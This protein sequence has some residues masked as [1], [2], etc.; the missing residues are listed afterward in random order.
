MK[1][2]L[3]PFKPVLARTSENAK[4]FATFYGGCTVINNNKIYYVC[5]E[6]G[7]FQ[8]CIPYNENTAH[9]LD[10]NEPYEE[11]EPKVWHVV[12]INNRGESWDFTDDELDRFIKTAV[13][14][15]KDITKFYVNRISSIR[16]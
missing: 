2:K 8:Y 14:N 16:K 3:E 13:I 11:P 6:G 9:L 7:H 10:T 5:C 4:W 12:N 1:H 15:N